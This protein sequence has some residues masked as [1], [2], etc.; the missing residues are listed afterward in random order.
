M[1]FT[2]YKSSAGSGKTST[3]VKEYL[4]IVLQ[5]PSRF[6]N[7]LAITFTNKAAAEM[8]ERILVALT[9]L[10]S[11]PSEKESKTIKYLLPELITQTGLNEQEIIQKAKKTLTLILHNY[12]DFG[13]C[14]IDSFTYRIVRTFAHDLHI[15]MNFD[16]EMETDEL[17]AQ[18]VDL[19]LNNVGIDSKLTKVLVD[20]TEHKTDQ[21][22]NWHVETD[23]QETAQLLLKE[24][25]HHHIEKIKHL[26][27]DDFLHIHKKIMSSINL[28][29]KNCIEI[30]E[31]A[32]A[33]ILQNNISFSSFSQGDKGIGNYFRKIKN[34]NLE[35][36]KPN[37]YVVA[38]IEQGKWYSAKATPDEKSG[39]DSI[40]NKLTEYYVSLQELITLQYNHYKLLLLIS[41][42]LYPVALLNEIH[43]LLKQI[44]DEKNIVH[45]SEFNQKI[46]EIVLK[47]PIPFIY[48]RLGERYKHFLI[49]EFQ[50]TSILQWQN[51]LPLIENS[52]SE[53]NFNMVVGDG[54]Q[55]IYRWRNG[56]V[57]Q[58]DKLP[59]LIQTDKDDILQEREN[60]LKLH[61]HE[62]KL[63]SNYRSKAELIDFNNQFF[64]IIS[65]TL[66]PDLQ[67]I[68]NNLEQQFNPEN[69]GGFVRIS[70][71][72]GS[73]NKQ[74]LLESQNEQI[75]QLI[76]ELKEQHFEWKDIAILCRKNDVASQIA[77]TLIEHN[78]DVVSAES[79]LLGNSPVVKFIFAILRF[80]QNPLDDIAKVEIINYL[81][82]NN[83]II[84]VGLHEDLKEAIARNDKDTAKKFNAF[85]Q[86]YGFSIFSENLII[87]PVYDICEKII[88]T[89]S[90]N[91]PANPDVEFYMDAVYTYSMRNGVS[92]TE[93]ID[94]WEEQKNKRSIVV[95]EEM[96]AVRIMTIHKAKGLEFPVVIF[97][98][99]T[100][101]VRRSKDSVWIDLDEPDIN[102][103][104]TFLVPMQ[105]SLQE[106]AFESL[107]TQETNKSFL[108]LVNLLY[109]VMTRPSERMYIFTQQAEAKNKAPHSIP[110]LLKYFL[111][112]TGL[113][114][115]SQTNYEFGNP[116][117]HGEG[118]DRENKSEHFEIK[119]FVS[120]EWR[121]KLML[122]AE[123]Y[124]TTNPENSVQSNEWGN[125]FHSVLAK[126]ITQN[127]IE[128]VLSNLF[129][130]GEISEKNK[131]ILSDKIHTLL[132][133]PEIQPYFEEGL[134]IKCE[135]EII[136]PEGK[137]FRPDRIVFY[138]DKTVVIDYKTGTPADH[139]QEQI[140]QY[141]FL[142]NE[143]QNTPVLKKII[144]IDTNEI[145]DVQ[146]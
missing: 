34:K 97:P 36:L 65:E 117:M 86:K 15:P 7:I 45:I 57:E 17:I 106:T 59:L 55:A 81:V 100:D 102:D 131:R 88:R 22:K 130:N 120:S 75:V 92:I 143:I 115:D 94:W 90:L 12:A 144:Y 35:S 125:L 40:K 82:K 43:K 9:E 104:K 110:E 118:A 126:I 141:A 64:R 50:D 99:A 48:E 116:I 76:I 37:N 27:I 91:I 132:S 139:H 79:L 8:K 23:L 93:F 42:N 3:L 109:V 85:L 145:I 24:E 121:E 39:I 13:I 16:V 71:S 73:F 122:R 69:T 61:Y 87:L 107:F 77:R 96:N 128:P 138:P 30:A 133:I 53:N 1:S 51:L 127:D 31:K 137:V 67:G 2:V 129:K 66:S 41:K 83:K 52:L 101:T 142:L 20:F 14:T 5:D 10:S 28:F 19:L 140:K 98:M 56:E 60:A 113:W 21:E 95:A 11:L 108:D 6:R 103:L 136:A 105:N 134:L 135:Q 68:Y 80:I 123:K 70:F 62:E 47:E 114:K 58:F 26:S 33:L 54:K 18:S 78:I 4:K 111:T 32:D 44:K 112:K 49:D 119:N 38:T 29:E 84:S 89:F 25:G 146:E 74:Q 124:I 46:A 63:F 72:D